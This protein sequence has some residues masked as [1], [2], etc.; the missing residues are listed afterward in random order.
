VDTVGIYVAGPDS[1]V[2]NNMISCLTPTGNGSEYGIN[3]TGPEST[4]RNN[5]ISNTSVTTMNSYGISASQS[6]LLNNTLSDYE[7]GVYSTGGIYAYNTIN[8]CVTP[9]TG[10]TAGAG[11]SP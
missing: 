8:N 7:Y 2:N 5:V 6:I 4:V 1:N 3:V 11:N 9:F 10:G